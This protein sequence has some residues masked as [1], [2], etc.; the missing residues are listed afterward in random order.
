[1]RLLEIKDIEEKM[2]GKAQ[3][4]AQGQPFPHI[5]IDNFLPD[6]IY[7]AICNAFPG[8]EA[9][10]WDR[11]AYG[12]QTKL[13]CN[14]VHLLPPIL[15]STLQTLNSGG[16]LEVIE[17]MT[18]EKN[19]ISDP[20]F[21]GG[22]IHQIE[23][24]GKLSVHADFTEPPHYKVFRRLNLLIYLNPDW[25]PEHGARFELWDKA[26]KEKCKEVEP[27]GNRCVVFTT[28]AHSFHGHPDPLAGPVNNTRRSLAL[29][30]YQLEQPENHAGVITR[31]SKKE[32]KQAGLI[33]R[34]RNSL[35]RVFWWFSYKLAGIAGRIDT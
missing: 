1:M 30:Y 23:R 21:V 17:N 26:G 6:E 22:G 29:Y 11:Y 18:G 20:H 15:R 31:W 35:S 3:A 24:G 4:Y 12:Y 16:F 8:P 34:M 5:V 27:L 28:T 2:A 10:F 9:D 14:K 33:A 19:L 32:S 25:K 13:A 7:Q